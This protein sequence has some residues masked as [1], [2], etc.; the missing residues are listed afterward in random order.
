MSE[1]RVPYGESAHDT[2]VTL[3]GA[4]SELDLD[5]HVVRT[6]GENVFVVPK[7][8]ADK[9]GV[10]TLPQEDEPE[11]PEPDSLL[12]D[13]RGFAPYNEAGESVPQANVQS[14]PVQSSEGLEAMTKAE[15]SDEIDRR[16]AERSED[17]Q[18]KPEGPNKPDLLKALQAD[19]NQE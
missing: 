2:A 8:V 14:P 5:A 4:A 3:L 15:L 10:D 18:I 6:T 11:E 13:P 19:D 7:E 16:N 1:V 9:A 17:D 12:T